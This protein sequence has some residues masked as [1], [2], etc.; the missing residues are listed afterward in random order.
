MKPNTTKRTWSALLVCCLLFVVD[1]A[2]ADKFSRYN[3]TKADKYCVQNGWN[4]DHINSDGKDRT[5]YWKAPSG[6]WRSGTIVVMHGGGGVPQQFCAPAGP[7]TDP[8]VHFTELAIQNGFA[9]FVL[10]STD[11]VTDRDGRLCGKVWDDEVRDRPNLD[12]PFIRDVINKHIALHRPTLSSN[13]IFLT[14]L[15]SGGYMTVR[16]ATEFPDLITAFAPISNGDPY[17]WHRVCI[18]Q[19]G[20]RK[21]VH[22]AGYD[23]DTG[24]E[25]RERNSCSDRTGYKSELAWPQI[26]SLQRPVFKLFHH[27]R[28]GINDFSCNERVRQ[29]LLA[30]G[31]PEDGR[32]VIEK[33]LFRRV[34][35]HFWLDEYNLPLLEFFRRA[36]GK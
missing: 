16:A 4:S 35:N 27:R 2:F 19:A 34:E 32:F 11:A 31:F 14:G 33:G 25:I 23:N 3:Q 28:D 18:A 12:L 26:Q 36:N 22:G 9:V 10:N 5:F 6:A 29:Q 24:K 30:H 21:T 7:L 20:G 1:D 8:Q 15:S 17:G 13:S